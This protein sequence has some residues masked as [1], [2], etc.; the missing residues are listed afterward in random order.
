MSV[1]AR[2]SSSAADDVV[3]QRRA[4]PGAVRADER[5]LHALQVGAAD[6]GVGQGAEAGG[7]A[8]HDLVALDRVGDDG[9]AG[10]HPGGHV[11]PEDGVRLAARHRHQVVEVE[12][13][14]GDRHCPHAG[15]PSGVGR[16][17][18]PRSASRPAL[19]GPSAIGYGLSSTTGRSRGC[20]RRRADVAQLV[21]H[22]LAKVRVA[23]SNPVVRS[24]GPRGFGSFGGVAE[25]R[26]N[27]LQ[28]RL[29]GF[30]SRLHLELHH[31]PGDW[32][33]LASALP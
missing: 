23:G 12:G 8:V 16:S 26:G 18:E 31:A 4:D 6:M 17:A 29:H 28:S 3:G 33:S 1:R 22:H 24:E 11:R 14:S 2:S 20:P 25:R 9:P 5:E 21:E 32:R 27:G 13:V 19:V 10:G 15:Q 7:D 30:K